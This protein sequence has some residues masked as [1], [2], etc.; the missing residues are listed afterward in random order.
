M[1][2]AVLQSRRTAS[3]TLFA[4]VATASTG[5]FAAFTVAPVAAADMAG[6]AWSGLPF[7]SAIVGTAVASSVLSRLMARRGRRPGVAL[8]YAL[9][10]LGALTGAA[11]VGRSSLPLLATGMLLVGAANSAALLSRYAAADMQPADRRGAAISFVLWASTAGALSGPSLVGTWAALAGRIGT[12][13]LV[14]PYVAA[15]VFCVAAA[16]VVTTLLRP[17][18]SLLVVREDTGPAAARLSI[19]DALVQ[20]HVQVA[21]VAMLAGQAVMVFVMTMTPVHISSAGHGLGS[22][23]L[24]MTG[25][26][27]GMYALAPAAGRLADRWG[28]VRVIFAGQAMLALATVSAAAMPHSSTTLLGLALVLLGTG[29]SFSFV[30]GSALLTQGMDYASRSRVQG[31]A[32]SSTWTAAAAASLLSGVALTTL[33]YAALCVI[34]AVFVGAAAVIVMLRREPVTPAHV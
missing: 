2:V 5:F 17:D 23:G 11:A 13:V 6:T 7:T 32:D 26:I 34:G 12:P 14:G 16:L 20:T 33:G 29:W 30:A 22:V 9:G 24:V 31:A 15:A 4:G 25:H 19:R 10:A 27:V 21:L 8:G 28:C 18:P 3:R 1:S